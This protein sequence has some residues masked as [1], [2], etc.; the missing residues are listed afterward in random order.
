MKRLITVLVSLM[1]LLSLSVPALA[2]DNSPI[3]RVSGNATVSL[4]A[5]TAVVQV[6]VNTRKESVQEAQSENAALMN[7]VIEAIKAAGVADK[8]IVTSQF[9]VFSSFDYRM[10]SE[11]REIR[12]MYY[13]VQNNVSVTIHDM[14][15]IGT[16]LDAAMAAGANTSYGI[17]FSSTEENEAYLKALARAYED[18]EKKAQVLCT[19]AGKN[20]GELTLINASQNTVDY[21]IRNVYSAKGTAEEARADTSIISGD[22]TVS[23]TVTLEFA[24]K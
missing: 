3:V 14:D 13:E 6:G 21:G 9:N 5:D 19:A 1:L 7:A 10:D 17:T 8:D 11:G 23:A 24:I 12:T 4:A 18:A 2:E 15:M 16:V 20:L 22:V